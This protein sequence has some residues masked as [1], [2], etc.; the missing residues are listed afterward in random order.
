MISMKLFETYKIDWYNWEKLSEF[1]SAFFV[2]T[3]LQERGFLLEK[4]G[5]DTFEAINHAI[6]DFLGHGIQNFNSSIDRSK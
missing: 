6:L 1:F 5:F 4:R 2:R 3:L